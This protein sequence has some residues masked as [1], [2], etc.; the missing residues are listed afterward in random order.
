MRLKTTFVF[1]NF[2][3]EIMLSYQAWPTVHLIV[4]GLLINFVLMQ[5]CILRIIISNKKLRK[6]R[7]LF[8]FILI[9]TI[10]LMFA[11]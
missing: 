10:V 2:K 1:G 6:F 8:V 11:R 5:L 7:T 3:S 4:F 9:Y